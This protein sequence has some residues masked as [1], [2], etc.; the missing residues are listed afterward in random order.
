MRRFQM[1][2]AASPTRFRP[3]SLA[4]I[5]QRRG[6]RGDGGPS[7]SRPGE[8]CHLS[9]FTRR[10]P[11]PQSRWPGWPPPSH[12]LTVPTASV[13]AASLVPT[14]P[15]PQRQ[16]PGRPPPSPRPCHPHG[17]SA[18]SRGG[19]H[20]PRGLAAG[21]GRPVLTRPSQVDS[22]TEEFSWARREPW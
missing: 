7:P 12:G 6:H 13:L 16:Q 5:D 11:R 1:A 9:P 15:R 18:G 4:A 21:A 22:A 19:P 17:L 10:P 14:A 2:K 8:T 3:N 20:C